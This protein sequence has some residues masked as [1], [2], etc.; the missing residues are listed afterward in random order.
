MG[1]LSN[2][3]VNKPMHILIVS[4]VYFLAWIVLR[5]FKG[6]M[7]H[8]PNAIL[9]PAVFAMIYAGWEWLVIV[10][11]PEAN[12]RVDLLLIWPLQAILSLWA[13]IK[14]FRQ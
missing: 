11:T 6:R 12:I 1:E 5:F 2:F 3:L 13:L 7:I 4:S 14:T 10:K 8:H 9:V